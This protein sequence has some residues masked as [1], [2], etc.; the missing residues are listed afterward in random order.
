MVL[1]DLIVMFYL[2]K[3]ANSMLLISN[4]QVENLKNESQISKQNLTKSRIQS[5]QRLRTH[6][7]HSI[8]ATKQTMDWQILKIL[9]KTTIYKEHQNRLNTLPHQFLNLT[10]LKTKITIT[11]NN[12]SSNNSREFIYS[13]NKT[14]IKFRLAEICKLFTRKKVFLPTITTISN[15]FPR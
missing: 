14:L 3:E 12:S 7:L 1:W 10:V 6:L 4:S 13:N 5:I 11:N 8:Q 2:R 15:L 9:N